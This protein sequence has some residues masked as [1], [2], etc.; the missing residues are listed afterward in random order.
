MGWMQEKN[1][2]IRKSTE[3]FIH[4]SSYHVWLLIEVGAL[5]FNCSKTLYFAIERRGT[6]C[7]S[8]KSMPSLFGVALFR[9]GYCPSY[10][11]G[12]APSS[13][14]DLN[15]IC[16]FGQFVLHLSALLHLLSILI[17][18]VVNCCISGFNMLVRNSRI[19]R[20]AVKYSVPQYMIGLFVNFD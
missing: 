19:F 14:N 11:E 18:F 20:N 6:H 17:T 15:S 9:T 3:L 4:F 1:I 8:I 16:R 10:I 5:S 13:I 2:L 7:F 12:G